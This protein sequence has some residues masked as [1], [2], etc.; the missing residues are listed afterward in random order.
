MWVSP[1]PKFISPQTFYLNDWVLPA[2]YISVAY[3]VV[4]SFK[5]KA[6]PTLVQFQ[7]GVICLFLHFS[8]S[9]VCTVNC[10]WN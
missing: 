6:Q 2:L 3:S 4:I 10:T 8:L 9:P 1:T 5:S 7:L